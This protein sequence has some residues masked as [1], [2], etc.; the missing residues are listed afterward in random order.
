M[1][2]MRIRTFLR[3]HRGERS[4]TDVAELTGLARGE[5]SML[6]RGQ[7]LPRDEWIPKL[8][9]VYGARCDWY[10]VGVQAELVDDLPICPG[11]GEELE[12]SASRRRIYHGEACR[13]RAR[14]RAA[15]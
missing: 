5:I 11:C 9:L 1:L 10:P 14:R 13:G 12:P 2:D 7:Q 3:L 15:A 6:E 8:E 4:I